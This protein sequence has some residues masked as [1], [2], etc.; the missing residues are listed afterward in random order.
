MIKIEIDEKELEIFI[1]DLEDFFDKLRGKEIKN[2]WF[3]KF[4]EYFLNSRINIKADL[5]QKEFKNLKKIYENISSSNS[6]FY[7]KIREKIIIEFTKNYKFCPYCW[8][9]PLIFFEKGKDKQNS[10]ARMFQL[11]HFFPKNIYH[12]WVINFYNLI[13]SCNACNHLKSDKNPLDLKS[14]EK[15]FHPYFGFLEKNNDWKITAVDESFDEKYSFSE[16]H[17]QNWEKKEI[18]YNSKH[19]DFF[20]LWKIYFHSQDTAENFAFIQE[21]RTKILEEKQRFKNNSKSNQEL[22]DYFFKNYAPQSEDE[23]LKFSNGKFKKDLID[24]LKLEQ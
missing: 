17:E 16:N 4:K 15:I 14:W 3:K 9:N 7:I 20:E 21:Q 23:I 5:K 8:K 22:K 13:P 12:K 24:N 11:D 1:D 6:E 19:S 2:L 18:I 10:Y